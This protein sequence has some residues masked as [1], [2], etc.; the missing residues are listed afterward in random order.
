MKNIQIIHTICLWVV[1]TCISHN[2][3]AQNAILNNPEPQTTQNSIEAKSWI[4]NPL[5]FSCYTIVLI[6]LTATATY[7][8]CRKKLDKKP[9]GIQEEEE[10]SYEEQ[11]DET[12]EEIPAFIK[13]PEATVVEYDKIENQSIETAV[14]NPNYPSQGKDE[15]I[16]DTIAPSEGKHKLLIIEDHKDIGMYLKILFSKEYTV[17]LAENGE[18]GIEVAYEVSPDLIISDVMMP[19]MNGF[20]LA[21]TLKEDINTC[22]IPI[23]LLTALTSDED[24]IRGMDLGADDYIMKPFN[25]EI[26]KSKV[27]QLIKNRTELKRAYT[28]LLIPTAEPIEETKE[29]EIENENEETTEDPFVTKVLEL[30][31]EN[32]QNE[33]FSVKKLA[34]MLNMSQPTLYRKIKQLTN[35]TI[36]E[37]IRGV[38]LKKAAELLKSK[39]YNVQEVAEAVGY[40][41]VPTFRKH[42]VDMYG[43]TPSAFSKEEA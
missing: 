19:I 11:P 3:S 13:Q 39:D 15:P 28:K 22:H 26:L 36:I 30:T 12:E 21:R 18:K 5:M 29:I 38:R 27:K 33:D 41:D 23:I 17:F 25:S 6:L 2:T 1:L 9:A 14:I 8:V 40:N 10:D 43:V 35:F 16:N 42:F 32:I 20:E 4:D 7:L 34:E 31:A 37:I 24:V